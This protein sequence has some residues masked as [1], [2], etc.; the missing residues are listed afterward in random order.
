MDIRQMRYFVTIVEEGTITAAAKKLHISQPPLSAQ[1][2]QL[3]E[4]LGVTLFE[5]GA[6]GI[7]LTE[8]GSLLHRYALELLE[9]E[10]QAKEEVSNLRLGK[11][12]SVRIGMVSS[13]YCKE[14]FLG[15]QKFREAEPD[16]ELK[17]FDANTFELLEMLCRDKIELAFIRTP[18]PSHHYDSVRVRQDTMCAACLP[19]LFQVVSGSQKENTISLRQLIGNPLIVYR[20]REQQ[21]RSAFSNMNLTPD[22]ICVNDD[23]RTCLML[24]QAGLGIALVPESVTDWMPSLFSHRIADDSLLNQLNLIKGK[25][26]LVSQS[27]RTFFQI[28]EDM[29]DDGRK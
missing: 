23:A 28:F 18:Y 24:A 14:L 21:I 10:S 8:A 12:G 19:E 13:C 29:A 27:A 16:V 4:E 26:T 22:I 20:R 7:T 3:E 5:R 9:L 17:I 25:D 1:M 11:K 6:R 2:H 15:L